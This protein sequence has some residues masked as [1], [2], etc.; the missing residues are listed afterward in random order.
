[1]ACLTYLA[2]TSARIGSTATC[3]EEVADVLNFAEVIA[4][5]ATAHSPLV[6]T[7]NTHVT[8][9]NRAINPCVLGPEPKSTCGVTN[10]VRSQG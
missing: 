10:N 4:G 7:A 6:G 8:D 1:M 3:R 5:I 2:T 9:L